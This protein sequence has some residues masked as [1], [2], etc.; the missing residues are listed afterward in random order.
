MLEKTKVIN[1]PHS[2]PPPSLWYT[3]MV[4]FIGELYQ[5]TLP[6]FCLTEFA[7][8]PH[9]ECHFPPD[10]Q[11]DW[12]VFNAANMD[13]ILIEQK[14]MHIPSLGRFICKSKH[15]DEDYFKVLTVYQNGWLV[16]RLSLPWNLKRPI[17]YSPCFVA[18][19]N[20]LVCLAGVVYQKWSREAH[21]QIN[22]LIIVLWQKNG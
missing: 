10:Y 3:K 14:H 4:V 17:C 8:S 16:S 22:R 1:V 19:L 15:W 20:S 21:Y 12:V 9:A 2:P 11:G 18:I 5:D 13:T 6:S 7:P